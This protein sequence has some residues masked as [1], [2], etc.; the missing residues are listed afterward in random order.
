MK[1]FGAIIVERSEKIRGSHVSWA[2]TS[3]NR[4]FMTLDWNLYSFVRR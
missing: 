3:I 1:L 4:E 2:L